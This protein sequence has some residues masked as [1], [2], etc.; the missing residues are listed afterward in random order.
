MS[1]EDEGL[2]VESRFGE[3]AD[4]LAG[5]SIG[6]P[7]LLSGCSS[8][9]LR[10]EGSYAPSGL[11]LAYTLGWHRHVFGNLWEVTDKELD[12]SVG[13]L[14]RALSEGKS[15][16]EATSCA[17]RACRLKHLTAAA[18]V[19]YGAPLRAIV[20]NAEGALKES[21]AEGKAAAPP[22]GRMGVA[23]GSGASSSRAVVARRPPAVR[24]KKQRV[25]RL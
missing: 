7:V 12:G 9:R 2:A 14:L 24:G 10:T 16:K 21:A 6:A 17:E 5:S 3:D 1:G 25:S 15:W 11:A 20:G 22:S 4:E 18:Q 23:S 8:A 19:H 13:S